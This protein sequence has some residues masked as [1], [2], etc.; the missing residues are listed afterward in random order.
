[1]QDN[2]GCRWRRANAKPRLPWGFTSVSGFPVRRYG[3]YV[4]V[5]AP[6]TP[7]TVMVIP[8]VKSVG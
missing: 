4:M 5:R 7:L 6:P 1:M 8:C 3:A 2:N